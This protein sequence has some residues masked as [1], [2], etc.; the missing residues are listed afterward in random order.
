MN[1]KKINRTNKR[2]AVYPIDLLFIYKL[3]VA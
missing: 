2:M 1:Y 3:S